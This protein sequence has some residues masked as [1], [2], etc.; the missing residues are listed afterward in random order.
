MDLYGFSSHE[1]L[2]LFGMIG[3]ISGVGPKAS[4]QIASIGSLHD[5][6]K[7]IAAQ[8]E[9]FFAGIHG[10]GRKKIQKIILELT[11]KIE[12]LEGGKKGESDE[13]REVM[14]ALINLGFPRQRAREALSQ[15]P[16]SAK[17]TEEKV[18]AALKIVR[19]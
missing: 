4:L 5:F 13:D 8:D 12:K 17:T 19:G 1:E 2:D 6:K 14:D 16:K 9:R 7:A 11:G 10:I 3:D 15:I 18:R